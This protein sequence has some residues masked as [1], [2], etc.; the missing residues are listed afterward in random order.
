MLS[1]IRVK[2]PLINAWLAI[3]AATVAIIIPGI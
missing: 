1:L 2:E 3:I